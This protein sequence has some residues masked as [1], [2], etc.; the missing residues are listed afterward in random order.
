VILRL[1][2]APGEIA[3]IIRNPRQIDPEVRILVVYGPNK[4]SSFTTPLGQNLH[5]AGLR[6]P[7][8]SDQLFAKLGE[9]IPSKADPS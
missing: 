3:G 4:D 6:W 9:L 8:V 1:R 7:V 2:S 5:T